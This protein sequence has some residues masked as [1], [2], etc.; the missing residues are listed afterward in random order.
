MC[1]MDI[2]H[3][4]SRRQSAGYGWC[5][6]LVAL[7][8]LA[9]ATPV[10]ASNGAKAFTKDHA[11]SA[12][13]EDKQWLWDHVYLCDHAGDKR[14]VAVQLQ[15]RSFSGK[16]VNYWRWNTTGPNKYNGCQDLL[17]TDGANAGG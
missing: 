14:A 10:A 13:Y 11:G 2:S 6:A 4:N 7:A 15:Y 17:L 8:L 3:W 12:W 5:G 1:V 9:G 16:N